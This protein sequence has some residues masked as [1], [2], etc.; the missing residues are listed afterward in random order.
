MTD[1]RTVAVDVLKCL[2]ERGINETWS[3]YSSRELAIFLVYVRLMRGQYSIEVVEGGAE[4]AH[5]LLADAFGVTSQNL[6]LD[7]IKG[8]SDG[9]EEKLPANTNMLGEK[10]GTN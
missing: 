3:E 8:A 2:S 6:S 9:G 1:P 4:L 7:L 10:Q 5:L